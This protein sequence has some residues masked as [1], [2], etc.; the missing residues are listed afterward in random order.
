M[1]Q[2]FLNPEKWVNS[3][4]SALQR[5]PTVCGRFNQQVAEVEHLA[6]CFLDESERD[7]ASRILA[8]A[9]ASPELVRR[10]FE[11]YARSQPQISSP[12]SPYL[13][14]AHL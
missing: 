9:G 3:G 13:G 1:Q 6:L 14:H 10:G 4:A 7:L 5:L 2:E 11:K 12:V 8:A